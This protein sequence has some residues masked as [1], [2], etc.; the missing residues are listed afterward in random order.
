MTYLRRISSSG[1]GLAAVLLTL[2][3]GG[4]AARA[5]EVYTLEQCESLALQNNADT[6]NASLDVRAARFQ[7]GEALSAYF[8]SVSAMG[9][10]FHALNPLLHLTIT[11][12]LGTSDMAYTLQNRVK[13]W[14]LPN[15][16]NTEY[17]ALHY[18]YSGA[19]TLSQPVFAGG[20]IVNG[21]RL[22]ALGQ[23]A[24]KVKLSLQKRST[25]EQVQKDFYQILALQEKKKTLDVL[26]AMLDTLVRDASAAV[27]AGLVVGSDLSAV[28]LKQSELVSGQ[29]RL[30]MGLRIA[31]MNLLNG[32]GVEYNPYPSVKDDK[33]PFIDDFSFEG[34]I[35]SLTPPVMLYVPE[36]QVA[37]TLDESRLLQMQV[38]AKQLERKMTIGE[39]LPSIAFGASYGYAKLLDN[40]RWNGAMFA[41]LKI[42]ITDWGRNSQKLERQRIEVQKAENQRDYLCGQ[43]TLQLRQIY[44]Q[45]CAEYDQVQIACESEKLAQEHLEQ[46]RSGYSAGMNTMS[47]L[48]QAESSYRNACETRI[49]ASLN[50]L[51][52]VRAYTLRCRR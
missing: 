15:G 30:T 52:T 28:K 34:S 18:G 11:D 3:L 32:I 4:A 45:L 25:C 26:Q 8:P 48:L 5:Q 38:Q 50:Y 19:V 17:N 1:R 41:V 20:R 47:E 39:T 14:A 51:S 36:E 24:S 12:V 31:K 35:D 6:R 46:L 42:P 49:D 22:A 40:P 33:R 43:L 16:V 10:A 13:E 21:N 9:I 23:Q 29:S 7:K 27:D 2:L 44:T 37:M